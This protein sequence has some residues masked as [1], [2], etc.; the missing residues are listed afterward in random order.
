MTSPISA[1]LL[2]VELATRA[3]T[4]TGGRSSRNPAARTSPSPPRG[5]RGLALLE[6]T[7]RD[8]LQALGD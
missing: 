1:W 2:R 4:L 8:L 5:L 6:Y 7:C 3:A